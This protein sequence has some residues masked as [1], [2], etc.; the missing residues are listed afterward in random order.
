MPRFD[1]PLDELRTY[2]PD[3]SEPADFDD[4]WSRTLAE[5]RAAASASRGAEGSGTT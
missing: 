4:F 5:A 3:V 2:R 1:L